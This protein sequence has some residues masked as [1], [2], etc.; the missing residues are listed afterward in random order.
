M[1]LVLKTLNGK[2]SN[3]FV[4]YIRFPLMFLLKSSLINKNK[5]YSMDLLIFKNI[6]YAVAVATR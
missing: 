5:S 4:I 2:N 3:S 6:H 1:S